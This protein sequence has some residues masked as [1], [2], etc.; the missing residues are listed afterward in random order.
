MTR[1]RRHL[2]KLKLNSLA[3]EAKIIRK[4]ES[5]LAFR[6]DLERLSP[7]AIPEEVFALGPKA[8]AA[9][10]KAELRDQ[11]KQWR[12]RSWYNENRE[13]LSGMQQHRTVEV[14]EAARSTSLAYGFIRGKTYRQIEGN[15]ML[16]KDL[17]GN[18]AADEQRVFESAA[19]MAWFYGAAKS[20]S[21]T[22]RDVLEWMEKHDVVLVVDN[23]ITGLIER[24]PPDTGGT[25]LAAPGTP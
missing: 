13:R 17:F 15:R 18:L 1:D 21:D 2:L 5:K 22:I 20:K 9:W 7:V 25:A 12:E 6:P 16:R 4:A 19:K 23:G 24:K 10:R 11:R 3:A 8:C 14:R